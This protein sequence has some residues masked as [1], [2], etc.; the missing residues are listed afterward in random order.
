[1]R[2][3]KRDSAVFQVILDLLSQCQSF[4]LGSF[5]QSG[6]L[7]ATQAP[8]YAAWKVRNQNMR[9]TLQHLIADLMSIN[10]IDLLEAIE[11]EQESAQW[12]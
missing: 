10:V 6:K 4:F 8:K 3:S 1:M 5:N 11:I 2:I 7:L 12:S 9:E